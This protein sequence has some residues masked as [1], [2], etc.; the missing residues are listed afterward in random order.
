M[1]G[2]Y[3]IRR[4]Q[5]SKIPTCQLRVRGNDIYTTEQKSNR[6]S[7]PSPSRRRFCK[8]VPSENV[9]AGR[10]IIAIEYLSVFLNHADSQVPKI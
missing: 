2:G 6:V 1:A 5:N 7:V 4:M 3:S 8:R 10:N 9:T